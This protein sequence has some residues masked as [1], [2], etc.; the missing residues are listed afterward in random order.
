M[1]PA[2]LELAAAHRMAAEENIFKTDHG[3]LEQVG[4]RRAAM[5]FAKVL[6]VGFTFSEMDALGPIELE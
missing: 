6:A 2:R 4:D 1:L 3:A 5:C